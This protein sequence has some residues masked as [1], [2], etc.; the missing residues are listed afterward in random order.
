MMEGVTIALQTGQ[1]GATCRRAGQRQRGR[2]GRSRRRQ[3]R[4]KRKILENM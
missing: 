1:G 3:K 2:G 4:N